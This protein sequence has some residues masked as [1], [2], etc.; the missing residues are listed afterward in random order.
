MDGARMAV[1]LH[2]EDE[3]NDVVIYM[4]EIAS[5]DSCTADEEKSNEEDT[6]EPAD[7]E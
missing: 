2:D 3:V 6:G 1:N 4:P 5:E 7:T